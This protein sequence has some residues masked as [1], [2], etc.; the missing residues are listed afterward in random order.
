MT[1]GL[2]P[3]SLGTSGVDAG[4]M[5]VT[6]LAPQLERAQAVTGVAYSIVTAAAL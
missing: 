2:H 5:G 3:A 1:T 6:R 4:L